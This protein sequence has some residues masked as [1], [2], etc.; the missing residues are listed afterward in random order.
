MLLKVAGSKDTTVIFMADQWHPAAQW[1]SRYLWMPLTIG[2]GKLWLPA[3][4]PWTI[5]VKTGRA[6]IID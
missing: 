5:D 2:D 1:D 3:P 4:H 6:A